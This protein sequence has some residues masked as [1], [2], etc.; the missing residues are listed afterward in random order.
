MRMGCLLALLHNVIL[1]TREDEQVILETSTW[2]TRSQTNKQTKKEYGVTLFKKSKKRVS[3]IIFRI[4]LQIIKLKILFYVH[5]CFAFMYTYVPC[6]H[7]SQKRASDPL[8]MKLD[9]TTWV[10]EIKSGSSRRAT[11]TLNGSTVSLDPWR[12]KQLGLETWL[13]C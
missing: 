11:S 1:D 5:R 8:G 10:V 6:A 2:H 3:Y 7:R 12:V 4:Q 13:S 9:A